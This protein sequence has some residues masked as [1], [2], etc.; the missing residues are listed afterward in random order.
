MRSCSEKGECGTVNRLDLIVGGLDNLVI[1]SSN[2]VN[3]LVVTAL[4]PLSLSLSVSRDNAY[5]SGGQ[6]DN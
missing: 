5:L 6:E 2:L 1:F 4:P 3:C